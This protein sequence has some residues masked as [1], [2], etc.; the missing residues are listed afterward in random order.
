MF[1]LEVSYKAIQP[2]PNIDVHAKNECR[3]NESVSKLSD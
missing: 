2:T 1:R 3:E